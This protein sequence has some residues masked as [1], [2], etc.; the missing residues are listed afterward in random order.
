MCCWILFARILLKTFASLFISDIGLQFSFSLA[1]L[2]G[3]GIR[4]MMISQNEF[5]SF[6]S[7]AIIWKSL[8]RVSL[9]SS[10]NFS[11]NLLLEPSGSGLLFAGRF[12]FYYSFD[13]HG[14]DWSVHVFC[15]FLVKFWKIIPHYEFVHFFKVVHFIGVQLLILVS[16]DLLYF[17]I[18]C[19]NCSSLISNF[20]D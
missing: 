19:C 17:C 20:I 8:I 15:C 9:S 14:Y 13:F 5:V 6:L 2:S 18:V 11:Q 3:F 16:Y 10:L 7:S 12:F 4:V 1:S